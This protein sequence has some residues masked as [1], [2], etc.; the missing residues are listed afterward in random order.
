MAVTTYYRWNKYTVS[1]WYPEESGSWSAWSSYY[2]GTSYSGYLSYSYNGAT[3]SFSTSEWY[4][5]EGGTYY[6][7]SG[8]SMTATDVEFMYVAGTE[9]VYYRER[10]CSYS[11]GTPTYSQGDFISTVQSTN[12]GAYTDG[13]NAD[14]YYVYI[15]SYTITDSTY[16]N[17]KTDCSNGNNGTITGASSGGS[18]THYFKLIKGASTISDWS[19]T[20]QFTGLSAG[21]YTLYGKDAQ[22]TS[23]EYTAIISIA[24]A[25][26]FTA[27]KSNSTTYTANNGTIAAYGT[28]GSG[29]YNYKLLLGTTVIHDWS[30]TASFTALAAGTY[31]L[32]CRDASYTTYETTLSVVILSP[33]LFTYT[34]TDNT[35]S[36]T[37]NGSITASGVG[38][39]GVYQFSL[40][41]GT[42]QTSGSFTGLSAATY[43]LLC[44][45]QGGLGTSTSISV[46]IAYEEETNQFVGDGRYKLY[47]GDIEYGEYIGND[48]II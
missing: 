8:S 2:A 4:E 48:R 27:A 26:I 32:K 12:R 28:S 5:G 40:N 25:A 15:G 16:S 17:T 37:P 34:K 1:T 22:A 24:A 30:T 18:G 35:S 46:T 38:G 23:T 20:Y 14:S 13:V 21:S 10:S 11:A 45:E 41:G 7:G 9:E 39:S 19:A 31:T 3:G 47:I 29:T 43:T 36:S 6:S 44:T 42:A 33:P